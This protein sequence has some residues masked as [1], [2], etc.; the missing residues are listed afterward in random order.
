MQTPDNISGSVPAALSPIVKRD[1]YAEHWQIARQ[2]ALRSGLQIIEHGWEQHV[3]ID[4]QNNTV[5]RYPRHQ[6]AANKL[7]DEVMVLR[8]INQHDWS[9]ALP[10]MLSHTKH[11][12]SYKLVPGEVIMHGQADNLSDRQCTSIGQGLGEFLAKFHELDHRVVQQK[13]TK[14]TTT[15]LEYY[16]TR[17]NGA[18]ATEF[19]KPARQR[20]QELLNCTD[21]KM[22]VVV[23]GDLHGPNIV[24]DPQTKILNGVIDFSE[25][26]IGNPHQEFR[27]IF[28]TDNR[29]LQPAAKSYEDNGGKRL[30]LEE[31]V[32]W[33]YVNEW[34]NLC[35][36]AEVPSNPTYQR[37]YQ[38]LKSWDQL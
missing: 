6:A 1:I 3:I 9:I 13:K 5:Y 37:A 34:S 29:L 25:V 17:I 20:L 36:F 28:M 23:H 22:K 35:Y 19:Y 11:Y 30:N 4:E 21:S 27:K 7:A 16:R 31:I 2:A 10:V 26:E 15:L 14:Q 8:A 18:A 32:L 12:S 33:A 38:H 24:I